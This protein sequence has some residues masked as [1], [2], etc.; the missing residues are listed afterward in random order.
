MENFTTEHLIDCL[1]DGY[2]LY[3]CIYAGENVKSATEHWSGIWNKQ[4]MTLPGAKGLEILKAGDEQACAATSAPCPYCIDSGC[5]RHFSPMRSD[6]M[7]LQPIPHCPICRMNGDS[8][9]AIGMG[10]I[11][12]R[13]RCR[14]GRR[15]TL[16]HMLFAPAA[17]LR[18]ISVGKLTD[19]DLMTIFESDTCHI[20]NKSGKT[21]ADG[22]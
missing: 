9:P 2:E 13:L 18:L 21:I 4:T 3:A 1:E 17:A 6:F 12:L 10:T 20:C 14:K 7:D 19:D 8:I 5:T 11:R 15:L 16:K 22:T